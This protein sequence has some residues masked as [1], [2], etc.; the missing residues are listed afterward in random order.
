MSCFPSLQTK[1]FPRKNVWFPNML[2]LHLAEP[3]PVR[4]FHA[5]ILS[6][7]HRVGRASKKAGRH[8]FLPELPTNVLVSSRRENAAV[9]T[10]SFSVSRRQFVDHVQSLAFVPPERDSQACVA[11][12]PP[13]KVEKVWYTYVHYLYIS[14][15][16]WDNMKTRHEAS[17]GSVLGSGIVGTEMQPLVLPDYLLQKACRCIAIFA[18]KDN[19]GNLH[20]ETGNTSERVTVYPG[21]E[22]LFEVITLYDVYILGSTDNIAYSWIAK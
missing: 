4:A 15:L 17:S 21:E 9:D 1:F 22:V 18:S 7:L 11:S 20:V 14:Y 8:R 12:V 13:Y 5:Q 19:T 16:G 2:Y 10:G 3:F 6:P